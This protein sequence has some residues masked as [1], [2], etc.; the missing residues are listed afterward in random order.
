[1]RQDSLPALRRFAVL[2][3]PARSPIPSA[4]IRSDAYSPNILGQGLSE[5]R[6]RRS[7]VREL[8]DYRQKK[9]PEVA[10]ILIRNS[11][12]VV[13][14]IHTYDVQQYSSEVRTYGH[15]GPRDVR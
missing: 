11:K 2:T 14:C 15:A 12:I 10:L 13:S 7:F 6:L 3:L 4:P 8:S 9:I 5:L 1:M